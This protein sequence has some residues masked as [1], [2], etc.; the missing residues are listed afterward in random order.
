MR[1]GPIRKEWVD[2][3]PDGN[4]PECGGQCEPECGK[5]PMGCVYGGFTNETSYWMIVDGCKLYHGL[6]VYDEV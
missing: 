3:Q 4:C 2:E 1:L 6:D 5:H